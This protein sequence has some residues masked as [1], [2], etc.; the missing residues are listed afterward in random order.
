[1]ANFRILRL[2]ATAGY[3]GATAL[4]TAFIPAGGANQPISTATQAIIGR[5]SFAKLLR[6]GNVCGLVRVRTWEPATARTMQIRSPSSAEIAALPNPDVPDPLNLNAVLQT[7]TITS[8]WSETIM[9]GPSDAVVFPAAAAGTIEIA[10]VD[11]TDEEMQ[12]F[13]NAQAASAIITPTFSVVS[14]VAAGAVPTWSGLTFF[15]VNI[16]GGGSLI[17]PTTASVP[18]DSEAYFI[19]VGGDNVRLAPN[20]AETLNGVTPNAIVQV[21]G[22]GGTYIARIG[23]GWVTTQS[24]LAALTTSAN[25]V[26]G[27]VVALPA[28]D[29]QIVPVELNFTAYGDAQ[30]PALSTAPRD[31]SYLLYRGSGTSQIRLTG[32]AGEE[33]NGTVNGVAYLDQKGAL[34]ITPS[35]S[36]WIVTAAAGITPMP[37][38]TTAAGNVTIDPWG[39][40]EILH[41]LT[42]AAGQILTLPPLALVPIGAPVLV[43]ALNAAKTV[44]GNAAETIVGRATAAANTFAVP[45]NSTLKFISMGTAWMVL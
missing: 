40:E 13:W 35:P 24:L 2:S 22:R 38:T 16:A 12:R 6:P 42:E 4:T 8:E 45:N 27:A 39:L 30:L 34:V 14:I 5:L 7:V 10:F 31:C 37:V 32:Q 18:V 29:A 23:T 9:V 33:I 1:M 17:L 36:G 20:G 25:A 26:A 3:D 11:M 19:D 43:Q 21:A 44:A 41:R 15:L 28:L